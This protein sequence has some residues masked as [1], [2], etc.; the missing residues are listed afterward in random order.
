MSDETT[1][2]TETP[3]AAPEV[4][5]E[6]VAEE[7]PKEAPAKKASKKTEAVAQDAPAATEGEPLGWSYNNWADGPYTMWQPW[8]I[9]QNG[10]ILSYNTQVNGYDWAGAVVYQLTQY[11]TTQ[12]GF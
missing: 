2:T 8:E 6:V 11:N 3:E 4:T 12:R 9:A 7:A 10:D 1:E 5:P